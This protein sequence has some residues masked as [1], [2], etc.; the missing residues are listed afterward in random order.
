MDS[1]V[2]LTFISSQMAVYRYAE[3]Y[4]FNT[5]YPNHKQIDLVVP[6]VF[7]WPQVQKNSLK[8]LFKGKRTFIS[9]I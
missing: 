8:M 7:R 1:I 3:Q 4:F 9:L 6:V 2:C 5:F